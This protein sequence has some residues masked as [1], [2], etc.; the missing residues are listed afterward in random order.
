V[1]PLLVLVAAVLVAAAGFAVVASQD[2]RFAGAQLVR[3][4]EITIHCGLKTAAVDVDGVW[5]RFLGPANAWSPQ[6][7]SVDQGT[8]DVPF[9]WTQNVSVDVYDTGKGLVA[10]GPLWSSYRLIPIEPDEGIFGGC[11]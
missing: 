7:E 5:Y 8:G 11:L 4:T 2:P 6:V 1:K 9:G 3:E 10:V